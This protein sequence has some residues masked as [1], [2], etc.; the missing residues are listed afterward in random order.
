LYVRNAGGRQIGAQV[1]PGKGEASLFTSFES[2]PTELA[3]SY[4]LGSV[5]KPGDWNRMAM[6]VSGPDVW[7]L[8]NDEP[9]LYASGVHADTGGV[10]VELVRDGTASEDDK[11]ESAIVV[12]HLELTA[13]EGGESGRAPA[14]P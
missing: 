9:V 2:Q 12:R 5:L 6:R 3:S 10:I 7:L 1:H 13:L 11:E 8:L 4:S 14:G